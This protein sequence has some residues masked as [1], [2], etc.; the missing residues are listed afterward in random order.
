[1]NFRVIGHQNDCLV[2]QPDTLVIEKD[3]STP[4]ILVVYFIPDLY[5]HF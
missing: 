1:M 5:S 3:Q 4:K 2:V